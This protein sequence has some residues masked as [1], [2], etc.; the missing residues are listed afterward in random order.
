MPQYPDGTEINEAEW[1]R[2]IGSIPSSCT[3]FKIGTT[4][5]AEANFYGGTDYNNPVF[6]TLMNNNILTG[7]GKF[8]LGKG[9]YTVTATLAPTSGSFELG[10]AG[11]ENTI[12]KLGVNAHLLQLDSIDDITIRDLSF[13]GT[14]ATYDSSV[15]SGITGG[16]VNNVL[17]ENCDFY[18][19]KGKGVY[20]NGWAN[21]HFKNC[22]FYSND[23]DGLYLERVGATPCSKIQITD[24][25]SYS[26]GRKGFN[27]GGIKDVRFG[28]CVAYS[29][30]EDGWNLEGSSDDSYQ[31]ENVKLLGCTAYSNTQNGFRVQM[32]SYNVSLI[33]CDSY[34][35]SEGGLYVRGHDT[36][37]LKN[38]KVLG[39]NFYENTQHGININYGIKN[40]KVVGASIY[41][42]GAPYDG[43][44]FGA[45][46]TVFEHFL[47]DDI[48]AY[49]DQTV[50]TQAHG[51]DFGT[52]DFSA[53]DIAVRNLQGEGNTTALFKGTGISTPIIHIPV[54]DDTDG[55]AT[56][57]NIGDHPSISCADNQSVNVRVSAY[58]PHDYH[59]LVAARLIVVSPCTGGTV[60]RWNVATDWGA[61]NEAYNTGSDTVAST[62]TT[63][64]ANEFE[65]L[66]IDAAFTGVAALDKIGITFNREGNHAND[67]LGAVLHV[68]GGYM[69][70]V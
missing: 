39:G 67:T 53:Q 47:F 49:D 17:V 20:I 44:A 11:R 2:L 18:N 35:N 16:T 10:G 12:L 54:F 46:S 15:W 9:T 36:Y 45:N 19:F 65:L 7:T 61:G 27:N 56:L 62:D 30:S 31:L 1:N 28:G 5:Y 52:T 50:A 68:V 22:R 38:F 40:L 60:M 70:Y 58:L 69:K 51:L 14:K 25:I 59:E 41:N 32:Q 63:L 24:C 43:I 48:H 23:Q 33:G 57:T 3:V 6:S 29:N 55:N 4:Y 8:C 21:S 64:V 26:N 37:P 34:S 66:N 42:T 13:D